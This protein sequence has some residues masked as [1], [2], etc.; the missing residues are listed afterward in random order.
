MKMTK[1][2]IEAMTVEKVFKIARIEYDSS[3]AASR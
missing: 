1:D 3:S 2:M